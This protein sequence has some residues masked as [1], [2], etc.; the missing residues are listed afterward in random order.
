MKHQVFWLCLLLLVVGIVGCAPTPEPTPTPQAPE[1]TAIAMNPP[2][3]WIDQPVVGEPIILGQ[4]P[5]DIVAHAASLG[6]EARLEVHDQDNR[7]LAVVDLGSPQ[8][9]VNDGGLLSR[10]EG[11]WLTAIEALLEQNAGV[12][13]LRLTVVVDGIPS[14]PL[15]L[16]IL[17]PTDTPTAT[18]TLTP[19]ATP[20]M[21][22]TPT[23][24]ITMTAT[25]TATLT[26]SATPTLTAS[27]TEVVNVE[28]VPK[29][30]LSCEV[31]PIKGQEALARVGP[32]YDRGPIQYLTYP[33]VYSVTAY[34]DDSGALWW[35]IYLAE[36]DRTAWLP[37]A[38]VYRTGSCLLMAYKE[39]PVVVIRPDPTDTPEPVVVIVDDPA[40]PPPPSLPTNTPPP[41]PPPGEPTY[42]P[43]PSPT[44]EPVP[45]IHFFYAEKTS[46]IV[47]TCTQIH[48]DTSYADQVRLNG[49]PT[50]HVGS[51]TVCYGFS[52]PG[53]NFTLTLYKDGVLMASQSVYITYVPIVIE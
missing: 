22:A 37:D 34:N 36:L 16:T 21:S 17:Q 25:A 1:V 30:Q 33:D 50:G 5:P 12:T 26:P 8:D 15:I 44:P 32:G 46:I 41:P 4:S 39:P 2:R 51:R 29:D 20:T 18:A 53:I 24:T 42:T 23:A 35:E 47:G 6:G 38:V 9:A 28:F 11:D 43:S 14:D 48:W 49:A 31:S 52:S 19:T 10:Y 40:N 45:V 13:Q 27:P 7:L 3:V